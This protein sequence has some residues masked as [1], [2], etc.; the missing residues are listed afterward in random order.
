[1]DVGGWEKVTVILLNIDFSPFLQWITIH[2]KEAI[3][4]VEAGLK[5]T[6]KH[7]WKVIPVSFI[8][9]FIEV[10]WRFSN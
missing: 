9:V 8:V 3:V 1:M 5:K 7:L 4:V 6:Y 2:W 10:T